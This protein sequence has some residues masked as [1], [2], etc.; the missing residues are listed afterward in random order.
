[1]P[2]LGFVSFVFFSLSLIQ[3][4]CLHACYAIYVGILGNRCI[5]AYLVMLSNDISYNINIIS[6]YHSHTNCW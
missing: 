2:E 3:A 5:L 6:K 4:A 1:M